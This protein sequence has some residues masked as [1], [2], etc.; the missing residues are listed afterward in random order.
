MRRTG[1]DADHQRDHDH[2][3]ACGAFLHD[4]DRQRRVLGVCVFLRIGTALWSFMS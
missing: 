4:R 1:G 3:G 2:L